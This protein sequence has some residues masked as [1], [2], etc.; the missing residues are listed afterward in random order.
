[1]ISPLLANIYLHYVFDLWAAALALRDARGDV[2]VVRYADDSVVGFEHEADAAGFLEACGRGSP[3]SGWR[4]TT[5][6]TRVIEFGR[7]AAERRSRAG[8]G[9]PEMFDFLGFTH[10]CATT[11]RTW[12]IH[13][14]TTDLGQADA[15][16]PESDTSRPCCADAM[17]RS[18]CLVRGCGESCRGT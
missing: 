14:Q 8:Q 2:I 12:A 5:T 10:I 17:S 18:Q 3:S 6:K 1:M 16:D 9:R 15:C 7:F 4:C 11:Q 13:R